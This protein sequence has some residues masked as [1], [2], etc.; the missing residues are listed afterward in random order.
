[1][2][3]L[4]P[5]AVPFH[6]RHIASVTYTSAHLYGNVYMRVG[7]ARKLANLSNFELPWEQSSQNL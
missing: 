4:H 3:I 1:M 6:E 7:V 5:N 2:P